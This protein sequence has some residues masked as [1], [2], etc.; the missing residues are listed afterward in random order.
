MG[1]RRGV[2]VPA[3]VSDVVAVLTRELDAAYVYP[4]VAPAISAT[5]RRH[6][7]DGRYVGLDGEAFAARLTSDLQEVSGDKHLRVSFRSDPTP[8]G[9]QDEVA[10]QRWEE[11]REHGERTNF[12]VVR[13]ERLAGNVALLELCEFFDPELGG[14]VVVAAMNLVA[15]A[16]ALIVDLR[17]NGGGSPAMVALVTSYL[18]DPEPVHLNDLYWRR[19]D[20]TRQFWTSAYVPG[21]RYGR[22][23]PVWVLTSRETFSGAE[24]FANNLKQLGRAVLVGE[25]TAGAAHPGSFVRLHASFDAFIPTG[26]PINPISKGDWEG[27]GV[28]PD[29][30]VPAADALRTAHAAALRHVLGR[31]SNPGSGAL[32]RLA[33]EAREALAKLDGEQRSVG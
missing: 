3:V 29:I 10:R 20:V 16:D 18:F 28:A 11:Y 25:T 23:K 5:V 7:D 32:R 21:R 14:E 19:G 2:L 33:D 17:W 27:V 13:V 12:G 30:D 31:I 24:E 22:E 6:L 26:R 4:E 9:Q 8:D 15:S 1:E